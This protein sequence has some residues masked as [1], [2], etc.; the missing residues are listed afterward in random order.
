MSN[1]TQISHQPALAPDSSQ[2]RDR[3]LLDGRYQLIQ[4]L[5]RGSFGETFI[6]KDTRR[7]GHPECVVKQFNP[8][9]IK[10]AKG[11]AAARHRFDQ[12]V[13]VLETLGHHDRIP[14]LLAHFE[15]EGEF[16]LVQEFIP[17]PSLQDVFADH[18]QWPIER[19][20]QLLTEVLEIL[21]FVHSQG[22]IHRDI[23]PEN[24]LYRPSDRH[25]VLIDFGAVKQL[26]TAAITPDPTNGTMAIYSEGYSPSE[27]L[28]GHPCPG[29]DLYAL[30]LLCLQGLTGQHP[31][32]FKPHLRQ[33]GL[34][35]LNQ[36]I[37]NPGLAVIFEKM[38]RSHWQ[39]RYQSAQAVL[40]DLLH[41]L[42]A[43][44][45]APQASSL[46]PEQ[47]QPP[48]PLR[49]PTGN[50]T[51]T[52]IVPPKPP[53]EE[54]KITIPTAILEPR[55]SSANAE[56]PSQPRSPRSAL[57][58]PV[59]PASSTPEPEP[60]RWTKLTQV[61]AGRW[62]QTHSLIWRWLKGRNIYS[63]E[64]AIACLV[65]IVI[66]L[67]AT[68][69]LLWWVIGAISHPR[70]EPV[71][72]TQS[73]EPD[74]FIATLPG[75]A[76]ISDLTFSPNSTTLLSAN[77]AGEITVWD[78]DSLKPVQKLNSLGAV[79][80]LAIS[81][82]G[83]QLASGNQYASIN[84][85]NLPTGTLLHTLREH[86]WPILDLAF[87]PNQSDLLS[88]AA[89]NRLI[90]WDVTHLRHQ[91]TDVSAPISSID[92]SPDGMYLVG[93]SADYTL[94]IWA[95]ATREPLQSLKGHSGVI[96][97]VAISPNNA[98]IVSGSAD[99]SIKVWNLYT[100]KLITTLSG[101]FDSVNSVAISPDSQTVVS[102]SDDGVIRIW[103]LYSGE[104]IHK[105]SHYQ[106]PIR[107]V[108][109]SPDGQLIASNTRSGDIQLWRMPSR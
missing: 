7:P 69:F 82:D 95:M 104:L 6:A 21:A 105:M 107:T 57:T 48:Q 73:V 33:S 87:S 42:S 77:D 41:S 39:D 23:K 101:H 78:L 31:N 108:S 86:Q 19:V 43:I 29:S 38:T 40:D 37:G 59:D 10:T 55:R 5:S 18:P 68:P 34:T 54:S 66:L 9:R 3:P 100:G 16:Y 97:S 92:I 65:C 85:W 61:C 14:R 13:V 64:E 53:P 20:V 52:V 79:T 15:S 99:H 93:G 96:N 83:K 25:W 4:K 84:L 32:V 71:A 58:A 50:H 8:L 49:S 81:A 91:A 88:S 74:L 30:G 70:W 62:L 28:E 89:D 94:K 24:I 76:L 22:V 35:W 75:E 98:V 46:A 109:I 51:P 2:V 106:G 11:L 103:S 26:T 36:A 60:N 47:P 1:T 63:V 45:P 12:E 27:Q 72:T 67:G 80:A 17:G 44:A 102:S 56:R 90:A